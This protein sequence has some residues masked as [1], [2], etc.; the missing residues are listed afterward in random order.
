MAHVPPPPD[1][2][3][4]LDQVE[5]TIGPLPL[6]LRCW[7]E[8]VGQVNLTG[9]HPDW[10]F[11]FTDALVVEAP[12]EYLLLEHETWLADQGTEW[13]RGPFVIDLAPDAHHKAGLTGGPPYA[14]ALPDNGVDSL[15][16]WE[17]HLTTF[18]NYLRISFQFAG[19]PGWDRSGK[20]RP[21]ILE[22]LAA[23]LLPI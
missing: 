11:E 7:Y 9:S 13:D 18:V 8:I 19:L 17:P 22:D 5:A 15:L 1:I 23:A 4:K 3:Q 20:R 16:L 21:P 12:V 10:D 6:A 2:H 14:M